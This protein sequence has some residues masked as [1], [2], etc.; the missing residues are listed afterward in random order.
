MENYTVHDYLAIFN[1]R[2]KPFLITV[3]A[4][5]ALAFVVVINWSR[6][7]SEATIQVQAPDIPE[8]M[9]TPIAMQASSMMEVL[10]DQQIQQIQQKVVSA[11]SLIDIITKFNLYPAERRSHPIGD[12]VEAMRKKI[13][14]TLISADLANPA[15]AARMQAGQLS[16]IAFTISFTYSDPL[17]A[18]RVANELV[19]RILDEDLKQ[20]RTQSRETADFLGGQIAALEKSLDEQEKKI[21]A[22]KTE[23]PMARPETLVLNQQQVAMTELSLEQLQG[24]ISTIERSRGDIR[25]QL[26][27]VDPYSRVI[28][29]G[30]VMTTPAIQLKALQA[31]FA[32]LSTQYGPDHPDVIRLRHQIEALQ[33]ELGGAEDTAN[34]QAEIR[35]TRTNLAAAQKT[36]GPDHP[37]VLELK[38]KLAELEGHLATAAHDPASH[39]EIKKDADNPAYLMLVA[40]LN[41]LE[42]QYQATV[43]QKV[44]LEHQRDAF[45]RSVATTPAV[46]QELA[47]LSR[48]YDN[49]QLRYRELKE[50]K[51]A[52]DMTDQMEQGRIAQRLVV[53]D[54]PSLPSNT[55]PSRFMLLAV[56]LFGSI[57]CGLAAIIV[58]EMV[59]RSVH[60]VRH[61]ASLTGD[62]PLVVVPHIYTKD[63]N[64]KLK[65]MRLGIGAASG[66]ALVVVII[67]FDQTV[68]PLDVLWSVV[69]NRLGIS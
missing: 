19:S 51:L 37:D 23:H 62:V 56:G 16:A 25:T 36:Y 60:G 48:D 34:V 12:V 55:H 29:D 17:T 69:A 20:H 53:I 11:S 61:I 46:E 5:L 58:A 47:S 4:V 44:A 59:S 41:S 15:I 66:V 49:A 18:Q 9:T 8:G 21:S 10:A 35:D 31:K 33:G 14:L 54:P 1:R 6:Y 27:S 40:Q 28:A 67:I 22:Y 52:A 39:T 13:K 65:R 63:E 68:M 26:A 30:Q 7:Q 43:Q 38:R 45:M 2:R 42:Q 3:V 32:T 50:K 57:G 24:Q 64:R